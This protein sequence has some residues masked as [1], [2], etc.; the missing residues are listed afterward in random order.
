M[1]TSIADDKDFGA[2]FL[3][4]IIDWIGDTLPPEDVFNADQL[5]SW[6]EDNGYVKED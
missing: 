4:P 3:D 5:S 6:A 2:N 1:T